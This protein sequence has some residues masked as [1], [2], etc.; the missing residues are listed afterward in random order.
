M[1]GTVLRGSLRKS[2]L[3]VASPQP[4]GA[5]QLG[6]MVRGVPVCP[7]PTRWDSEDHSARVCE[8]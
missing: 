2:F 1:G 4:M 7:T 5:F 6:A 3:V 8:W